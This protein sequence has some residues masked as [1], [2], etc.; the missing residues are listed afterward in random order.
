[1]KDKI[2]ILKACHSDTIIVAKNAGYDIIFSPVPP[3]LSGRIN[4]SK[5]SFCWLLCLHKMS[6]Y[7]CKIKLR[8][9]QFLF[10]LWMLC[11]VW[12]LVRIINLWSIIIIIIIITSLCMSPSIEQSYKESAVHIVNLPSET[13]KYL[14]RIIAGKK[15]D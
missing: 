6:P 3:I 7:I 1:M 14:C 2:F 15:K 13:N 5:F 9:K 4:S 10:Y 12:W 11:Y 8:I